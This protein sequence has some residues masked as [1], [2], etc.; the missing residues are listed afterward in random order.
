MWNCGLLIVN[1]SL[2]SE[3]DLRPQALMTDLGRSDFFTVLSDSDAA[4]CWPQGSF[5]VVMISPRCSHVVQLL[6]N[7]I[8]HRVPSLII[9]CPRLDD[10]ARALLE[11]YRAAGGRALGPGSQ[12]FFDWDERL[13]LC[14][15]NSV[16]IPD[17]PPKERHVTLIAHGGAIPFS[18]YSM[19]VEAGVHFR[20]V[21]SLGNCDDR[22]AE[23]L[24]GIEKA[25]EDPMT[26]LLILCL[27]SLSR[28]RDFLALTARSAQRKLPVVLLRIGTSDL[29]GERLAQRHGDA[30]WTDS[31]MWESVAGQYGVVLLRDAQQIVDLGKISGVGVNAQGNRVAVLALSEGIAM[32]QGDQ[33]RQAGLE[34]PAFSPR[35]TEKIKTFVPRWARCDN[36]VDLSEA[37]FTYE[38]SLLKILDKLQKSDECDMILVAT[39][40]L[41]PRQGEILARAL[42]ASHRTGKKPLACCCLSRMRPLDEMVSRLNACGI[43]LFSSS[44]RVAEA[45]ASLWRIGRKVSSVG[46]PCQ[47]ADRPCLEVYPENLSE[48]DAMNLA[49]SYG[50]KTVPQKFCTSVAQVIEAS[51]T[52]GFPMALKVV[53]HSF[54]SKQQARAVALNLRTAEELRNAYG[55]ILERADRLHPDAAV[56]GVYAQKMVT[57]GIECMIGIKRD[58][59]FG[60]VVAVALGGAYYGLMKD[61][62][63]RV[64]PVT[65]DIARDMIAT[66]K[67]YPLVSGQWFGRP[68]DVE[69]LAQQI[70]RLS[71][72][73]CAEPDLELMDIN[74]IF[75]RPKG[76][77]AEIADAFVIRRKKV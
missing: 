76:L 72:M 16:R 53:S 20:R 70:V 44:R 45:M 49:E 74:P 25:I 51:E 5:D 55:R 62:A 12:G 15:S 28:G 41:S 69:A 14:W 31:V 59:L 26:T 10:E 22:D 36:P 32:I 23:L 57:D 37:V 4:D 42:C 33:C 27:E 65:M 48:R 11:K 34:V 29:F 38:N 19:A 9:G 18:L 7:C 47:P 56:E 63:L 50:L 21:L 61:I 1:E 3:T 35:L 24:K 52:L 58:P 66:L 43:P 73:A 40:A 75:V 67:G 64:A 46:D 30:A 8:E 6:E 71:L 60:P 13:A 68:N 2:G 17:S 77:G 39:G 54:F